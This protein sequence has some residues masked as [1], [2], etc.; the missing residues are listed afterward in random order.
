MKN[1]TL[2]KENGADWYTFN[3]PNNKGETMQVELTH[4]EGYGENSLPYI[5]FKKGW[6][7]RQINKYLHCKT[8]VETDKGCF[9]LYNPQVKR[10]DDG[11]RLVNNFEWILEDTAENTE[12]L[13][14]EIK[15]RFYA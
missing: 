13:I 4:C 6:T 7:D 2:K 10:S 1:Y 12:L 5:W 9:G 3:Q 11:K 8:Y 15:K 14:N